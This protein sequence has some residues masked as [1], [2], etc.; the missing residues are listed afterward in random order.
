LQVL[1]VTDALTGL[2]NRRGLEALAL[3]A[4]AQA[5]RAGTPSVMIMADLDH[6]KMINDKHGHAAGDVVLRALGRVILETVR[7]GDVAARIGGE[8]FAIFLPATTLEGAY[9]LAERL[10]RD[11]AAGVPHPSGGEARVTVSCGLAAVGAGSGTNALDEA[12]AAADQALYAAKRD[13]RDRVE[14]A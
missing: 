3:P 11:V 14:F 6:F 1:S 9:A 10:R 4:V 5:R 12:L 8:E 7:E 13:G 2:I